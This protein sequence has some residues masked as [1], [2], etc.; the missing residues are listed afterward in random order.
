MGMLSH[1]AV[2]REDGRVFAHLHPSGNYS[3]AA[4]SYFLEKV[5][6][7]AEPDAGSAAE[8]DHAKMGH[9]MPASGAPSSLSIPYEFP[10]P[11]RYRLWLQFKTGDADRTAVFDADVA[12]APTAN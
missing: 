8:I 1:A 4:Q 2:L 3:M 12:E 5:R 7:E 6:R 10:T 9:A 11:G